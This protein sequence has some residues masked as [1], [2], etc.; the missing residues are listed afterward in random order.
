MGSIHAQ[1]IE[2]FDKKVAEAGTTLESM[3]RLSLEIQMAAEKAAIGRIEAAGKGTL[4]QVAV[5]TGTVCRRD[6][7]AHAIAS[8]TLDKLMP[9]ALHIAVDRL[10]A[11]AH[12]VSAG[13]WPA[14]PA[15]DSVGG[16]DS[17]AAAHASSPRINRPKRRK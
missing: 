7:A 8:G 9:R 11:L 16:A 15:A 17:V 2:A 3:R 1:A 13:Q 5:D 6:L 12:W 10:G 14:K 4:D